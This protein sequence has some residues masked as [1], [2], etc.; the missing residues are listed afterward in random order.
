MGIEEIPAVALSHDT[1]ASARRSFI[2]K[3]SLA[4]FLIAQR[5]DEFVAGGEDSGVLPR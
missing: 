2:E 1:S 3:I 5:P 4:R